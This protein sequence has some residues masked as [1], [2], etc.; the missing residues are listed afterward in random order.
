M[1]ALLLALTIVIVISVELFVARGP[2]SKVP[3]A[4][5]LPVR[6]PSP[7]NSVFLTRQHAW[8]RMTTEGG[9]RVGVDDL[10]TQL[11]G[12]VESVWA[13]EP[14]T[15]L[16]VGDPIVRLRAK[17]RELTVPSPA[18]GVVEQVNTQVL[19]S[20]WV[21]AYDAY[22]SGWVVAFQPDDYHAAIAGRRIGA[23]ARCWLCDEWKRA[24]AFFTGTGGADG[25]VAPVRGAAAS[26][27]AERFEA[28]SR[29]FVRDA[30]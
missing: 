10:L 27:D 22:R 13:P 14:G 23:D 24:I 29:S 30:G 16:R 18:A 26:L 20:P 17:G 11:V 15:R 6:E 2:S 1:V 19:A 5:P 21:L 4:T 7:P 28:F 12:D 25:H 9:V 3:A 8:M